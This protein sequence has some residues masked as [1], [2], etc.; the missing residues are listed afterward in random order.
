MRSGCGKRREEKDVIIFYIWKTKT[1][2]NG[3]KLRTAAR[4]TVRGAETTNVVR[5]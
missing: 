3:D 1:K 4:N 2:I 5:E